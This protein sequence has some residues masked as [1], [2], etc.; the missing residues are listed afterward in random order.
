MILLQEQNKS[1][2]V[3]IPL[4][5]TCYNPELHAEYCS[6]ISKMLAAGTIKADLMLCM[7]VLTLLWLCLAVEADTELLSKQS[8]KA[9]LSSSASVSHGTYVD[10]KAWPDGA[11]QSEC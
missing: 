11:L 2:R 4:H 5:K 8:D 10:S 6:Y 3:H 1:V 9:G 7:S